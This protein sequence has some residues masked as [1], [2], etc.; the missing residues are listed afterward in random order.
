MRS[1]AV[2]RHHSCPVQRH[3]VVLTDAVGIGEYDRDP[4]LKGEAGNRSTEQD[5]RPDE[6]GL[7]RFT[8][9]GKS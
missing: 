4:M 6:I 7:F 5:Y 2:S 9:F 8:V 1:A 3:A